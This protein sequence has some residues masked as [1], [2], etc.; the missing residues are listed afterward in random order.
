M[1]HTFPVS[2][3]KFIVI[4]LL[5]ISAV[6]EC[7]IGEQRLRAEEGQAGKSIPDFEK[8]IW[9]KGTWVA[10]P[11][12]RDGNRDSDMVS[13]EIWKRIDAHT[14]EGH[15]YTI[16]EGDTVFTEKLKLEQ[17][18]KGIFYVATVPHNPGPVYFKLVRV[19]ENEAVFE[20]P[21]HDFPNRIIYRRERGEVETLHARIEGVRKGKESAVDFWF[22]RQ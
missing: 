7:Q 16:K 8:L 18:E 17:N 9:L 14:L 5:C 13:V 3:L 6:P 22:T 2:T 1:K 15:S 11:S 4:G 20:N 10:R 21:E 19:D 12:S